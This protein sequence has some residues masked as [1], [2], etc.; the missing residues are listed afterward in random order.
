MSDSH[1]Y[2]EGRDPLPAIAEAVVIFIIT[3]SIHDRENVYE[4]TRWAWKVGPKVRENAVYALGASH[5]V[6]KGAYRI[7]RW[8]QDDQ[9]DRW[10]F[11]G[12]PAPE[13]N[14]LETSIAHLRRPW[15]SAFM[16]FPEGIP[17]PE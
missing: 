7:D 5:G 13:L 14:A 12:I 17:E 16:Y 2:G 3:K 15:G 4:A 6:V 10:R 1:V 11:E 8:E 9:S